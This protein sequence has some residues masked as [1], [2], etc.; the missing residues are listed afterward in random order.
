MI[1]TE[2]VTVIGGGPNDSGQSRSSAAQ[3]RLPLG[4]KNEKSFFS[5]IK[6]KFRS[7]A[8]FFKSL[9]KASNQK[10]SPKD[11][12]INYTRDEV[13]ESS[14]SCRVGSIFPWRRAGC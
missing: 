13:S 3:G 14:Q 4:V 9:R 8:N 11:T 1:I 2:V 12:S 7:I 5:L 6:E 10:I